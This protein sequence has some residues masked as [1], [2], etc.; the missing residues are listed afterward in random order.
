[1]R[2][3]L[4]GVLMGKSKP[5]EKDVL[6]LIS[7]VRSQARLRDGAAKLKF[8]LKTSLA[9]RLTTC[10]L[11]GLTDTGWSPPNGLIGFFVFLVL[12]FDGF[13]VAL[14]DV[15]AAMGWLAVAVAVAVDKTGS[16]VSGAVTCKGDSS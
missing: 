15:S 14:L 11:K 7:G 1:M 8:I 16:G 12:V 10:T 9:R 5:E 3:R 13:A 6:G 2:W 4:S